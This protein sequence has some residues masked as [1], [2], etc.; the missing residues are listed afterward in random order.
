MS[1]PL[2]LS[3]SSFL[4]LPVFF[5]LSLL[6]SLCPSLCLSLLLSLFLSLSLSVSFFLSLC[7][8]LLLSLSLFSSSLSLIVSVSF[9]QSHTFS[10][11]SPEDVKTQSAQKTRAGPSSSPRFIPL[12]ILVTFSTRWF[13]IPKIL[14]VNMEIITPIHLRHPLLYLVTL[15]QSVT[16][17]GCINFCSFNDRFTLLL[18]VDFS[19]HTIFFLCL[20]FFFISRVRFY[21]LPIRKMNVS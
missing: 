5:S 11:S 13:F 2:S 10:K 20:F 4:S 7:L 6:L 17:D 3:L 8:S 18:V 14:P 12:S 9:N 15:E 16:S 1:V 19:L 21:S